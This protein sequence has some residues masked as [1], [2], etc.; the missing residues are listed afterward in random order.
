MYPS[1]FLFDIPS[2]AFVTLSCTNLFIGIITTVTTFVL[3]NFEDEELQYVGSILKEVFLIFPQYCL[4]RGLMDM[5]TEMN[6]NLIVAKFGLISQRDR[7]DWDFLGKY[8]ACMV[9]Q[10][11]VFAFL[12]LG[13]QYRFWTC[14]ANCLTGKYRT[15]VGAEPDDGE[16]E[17]V[18]R[19]RERVMLKNN[20]NDVLA[21][22]GLM[23]RYSKKAKLAVD[24]L[25]F[26]VKRGEC[27]GLLGVNGAG[28]TTTFK[29]LTGD[30]KATAGDALVSG[31]SVLTELQSVRRSLGYCPQ[32]DALNPLL[33]GREHLML[34]GRLRGLDGE[35]VRRVADWGL[36][37]LGLLPYGDRC[38][39][40]YSGGNKRKLSTAIA[41]VGNPSVVFLDEPTTGMDP[42]ARRFLWNCILEMI[43]G[44]QSVVLTSHSMEECEALCTRMGIMVNGR[45]QCLGSAQHLKNRFGSGYTLTLR[46]DGRPEAIG[47]LKE[48]V[49]KTFPLA[50][51]KEEHYNQLQYQLPPKHTKLPLVFRE[52]ELAKAGTK[53]EK[54]FLEDY[55]ITQTTLD[56]VCTL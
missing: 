19:E 1:S 9:L 37:K 52:M 8:M 26:G 46:S 20:P 55:S 48:L 18:L 28:K 29:M 22:R 23:K 24:R 51:L 30:T 42:G 5:A 34:Y 25:T 43:R 6:L 45:F 44:G 14:A 54:S 39:G 38:A 40:T 41:L 11:F 10:G 17:D 53:E 21:V 47:K 49:L 3:E 7:Y 2:S 50:E 13:I 15:D 35:A 36:R 27:F 4:G 33:T 32:F 56:E 31:R 16:D 12:T